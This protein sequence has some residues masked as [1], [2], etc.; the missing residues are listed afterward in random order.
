[1]KN[2]FISLLKY[3]VFWFAIFFL[4]RNIFLFY[5]YKSNHFSFSEWILS[6]LYSFQLDLA[7][8]CY[9]LLPLFILI[10]IQAFTEIKRN[11]KY[12]AVYTWIFL[13]ISNFILIVDLGLFAEWGL[14][15]NHKA[16]SYLAY[17]QEVI[18]ST[19]VTPLYLLL[20]IFI[21]FSLLSIWFYNKFINV[22]FKLNIVKWYK[23]TVLI[24]LLLFSCFLGLR[25]GLQTFPID[26]SWS[27]FSEKTLLNQSAVNSSWNFVAALSEKEEFEV[28]PYQ[29][30]DNN[31]CNAIFDSLTQYVN[32][33]TISI[34]NTKKPNIILVLLEGW[35]AEAMWILS[36][37]TESTPH[38]SELAKQGLL[39]TNFISTGFRTEQALAAITA[40]FP[41]QPKT[42][43][44]RKFGK[45]DNMP[46]FVKELYQ[47][48]YHTSYYYGGDLYF[49]NTEAYLKS[50]GYKKIIGQNDFQ[51][52]R[53]TEWGA[54]DDELFDYTLNDLK[55]NKQPFFSMIMTST[56]HEPFTKE[57]PQ[58]FKGN[59]SVDGYLNVMHFCDE[60][61]FKFIENSKKE[62]WY[63]NTVFLIVTDHTSRFPNLRQNYE[64]ERHWIPCLFYGP[65]L[66]D[67]FKGKSIDYPVSHI[68]FPAII[69]SQLGLK[70]DKFKWSKNVF[71]K[72][73][74]TPWAFYTFDEGFGFLKNKDK[75]VYDFKLN[76]LIVKTDNKSLND[77]LTKEGKALLQKLL[78]DY[79]SLSK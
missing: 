29:F 17:P 38:F 54:F 75:I 10:I 60:S 36:K 1:M 19:K 56:S 13:I 68:D 15:I 8:F 73:F 58:I 72:N 48:G 18:S 57:V 70:Y 66:K 30:F 47:N 46:S 6:N 2:F 11:K 71:N 27:Y 55:N 77:S 79:I 9:I 61:L 59:E 50:A 40:G 37:N 43:I 16:I 24:I 41:S 52:K 44:I 62:S 7:T 35:S 26:R 76:K 25:G 49:A 3:V 74:Q 39:F 51:Y 14:K 67:N 23:K 53:F 64:I 21:L 12:V 65:A 32:D 63:K 28:N 34:L 78:D 42:T 22:D 4:Q 5:F 31:K 69:L 33:S 45:F 20:F